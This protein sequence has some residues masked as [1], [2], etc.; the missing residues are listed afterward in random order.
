MTGVQTCA[1]PISW[2][3]GVIRHEFLFDDFAQFQATPNITTTTHVASSTIAS[4]PNVLI[5]NS[6]QNEPIGSSLAVAINRQTAIKKISELVEQKADI[7]S[8]LFACGADECLPYRQWSKSLSNEEKLDEVKRL[9]SKNIHKGK[10]DLC[11]FD[12]KSNKCIDDKLKLTVV[13][14]LAFLQ[15]EKIGRAHV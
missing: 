5:A 1:L 2:L 12:L 10:A 4:P 13:N 9:F 3:E 7:D 8:T 11:A 15:S 14:P 6:N